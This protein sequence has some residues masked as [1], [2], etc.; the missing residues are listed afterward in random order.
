MM[1]RAGFYIDGF[2][3][4][5][6]I[7][8]LARREAKQL[9]PSAQHLKWLSYRAL[10][11]WMVQHPY[12]ITPL[13]G[14]SGFSEKMCVQ[15][16]NFYTAIPPMHESRIRRHQ[17]FID[18]CDA[19]GVHVHMGTFKPNTR[20]CETC[21]N[22]VRHNEEKETDVHIA[23]DVVCDALRG[24]IDVAFVLTTDSDIAPAFQCVKH[25]TKVSLVTVAVEPRRHSHELYSIAHGAFYVKRLNLERS[26]LPAQLIH[27]ALPNPILRPS[28][29]TPQ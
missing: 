23:V 18:A 15:F 9:R 3:M 20:I 24:L 28:K 16:V 1:L 7:N 29:Y 4:Y 25:H 2:N 11:E 19:E 6:A 22:E 27:P 21:G 10:A 26:L 13:N 17:R 14:H 8:D 12:K 5:G